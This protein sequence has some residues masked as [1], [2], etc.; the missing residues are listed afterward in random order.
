[1]KREVVLNKLQ[2]HFKDK[3]SDDTI[4]ALYNMGILNDTKCD[5]MV[6]NAYA[7]DLI[8]K[9][10]KVLDALHETAEYMN[11]SYENIRKFYY[12][13]SDLCLEN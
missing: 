1:M 2:E 4:D 12:Y 7:K 9:G 11:C 13:Y 5:A 6:A 3:T 10:M 8:S